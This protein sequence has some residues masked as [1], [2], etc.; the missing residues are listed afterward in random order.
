MRDK[1]MIEYFKMMLKDHSYSF[2]YDRIVKDHTANVRQTL[3]ENKTHCLQE[4]TMKTILN[5]KTDQVLS[6]IADLT[7]ARDSVRVNR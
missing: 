2:L 5:T 1:T 4:S 6:L 7:E 3:K